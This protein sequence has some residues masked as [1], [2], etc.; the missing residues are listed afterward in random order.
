MLLCSEEEIMHSEFIHGWQSFISQTHV[1]FG[2]PGLMGC[3][4]M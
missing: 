2:E 1:D 3:D 4:A